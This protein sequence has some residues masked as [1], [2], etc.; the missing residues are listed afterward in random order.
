MRLMLTTIALGSILISQ[1][2]AAE[3]RSGA[4]DTRPRR[5]VSKLPLGP[6]HFALKA[7]Q[8]AQSDALREA[9]A[10]GVLVV[11]GGNAN[12]G[13]WPFMAALVSSGI[14][15]N[16]NGQFCGGSLI[17]PYWILTAA[18]CVDTSLPGDLDVVLGAHDLRN[19]VNVQRIAVEEIWVHPQWNPITSDNDVALLRRKRPAN[20]V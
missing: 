13:D 12:P 4:A 15:D 8:A 14:A 20:P 1:L 3:I 6:D 5:A 10:R 19:D 16:W 7:E 9:D 11:G 18:H 17:H 2:P